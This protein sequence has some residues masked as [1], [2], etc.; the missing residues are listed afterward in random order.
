MAVG[1]SSARLDAFLA[2]YHEAYVQMH[3]GD[4][5][6]SGTA[7][8]STATT[9][10]QEVTLGAP[11]TDNGNRR[12][13]NNAIIRW[14]GADVTGSQSN[15]HFSL[16]SAASAGTFLGSGELSG[17]VSFVEGAPAEIPI[18]GLVVTGGPV[19]A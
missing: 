17:P 6:A 13:R 11:D 2:D 1:A 18:N 8:V 12:R 14:E 19:A 7:N 9:V 5:G 10:R 4:P 16:W 15:T 3:S